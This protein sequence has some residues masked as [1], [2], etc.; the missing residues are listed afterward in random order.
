[1]PSTS[2]SAPSSSWASGDTWTAAAANIISDDL[3]FLK[4]VDRARVYKSG[5]Q[6]LGNSTR[7]HLSYDA[8]DYDTNGLHS[9]ASNT[10]RLTAQVDGWYL[11]CVQTS[12]ETNGTGYRDVMIRKNDSSTDGTSGTLWGRNKTPGL[13]GDETFMQTHAYVYLSAT[14]YVKAV[15]WQNSGGNLNCDSWFTMTWLGD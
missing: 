10:Q 1:M 2:W 5:V 3:K 8:E 13:S 7:E 4:N 12:F 11:V 6:V 15:A 9:T 14:D